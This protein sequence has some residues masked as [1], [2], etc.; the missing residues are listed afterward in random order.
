MTTKDNITYQFNIG[1]NNQCL[2]LLNRIY[3]NS[4]ENSRLDRKYNKYLELINIVKT[5]V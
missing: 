5:R 2:N 4:T 1:G 3:E